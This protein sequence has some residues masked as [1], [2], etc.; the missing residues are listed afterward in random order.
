M[1]IGSCLASMA[2][3]R[4]R[5]SFRRSLREKSNARKILPR[6]ESK[7]QP[8]RLSEEEPKTRVKR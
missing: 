2:A 8:D 7:L 4:L 6:E 1:N 3:N 5:S